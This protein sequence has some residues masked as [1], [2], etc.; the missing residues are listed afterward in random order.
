MNKR[1]VSTIAIGILVLPGLALAVIP[2][3]DQ[4]EHLGVQSCGASSCH[5]S[6]SVRNTY[7]VLQNEYIT[8]ARHDMHSK[9]YKVLKNEQSQRIAKNLGLDAAHTAKICL[10]CHS[11]NVPSERRGLQFK[12]SDGV[13]CEACHGGA[14][15]WLGIHI[16]GGGDK[17]AESLAAG[18]YPTEEPE[19]RAEL[20]L[21]CH[22]GTK[23]KFAT[24][25]IMGAGHPR[26]SFDLQKFTDIQ[27]RHY[28]VDDDY[29]ERKVHVEDTRA[30][31]M[32]QVKASREYMELLQ[33][34]RMTSNGVFPELGLFDCHACHHSIK[35][36]RWQASDRTGMPP[37]SVLLNDSS[38]AMSQIIASVVQ[39]GAARGLTSGIRQLHAASQ[40]DMAS[41]KS[42]AAQLESELAQLAETL[43]SREFG[44]QQ[45]N[46]LMKAMADA[47]G[48]GKFSDYSDAE[49]ATM[50]MDVFSG[51]TGSYK[52]ELDAMYE[53]V[54]DQEVQSAKRFDPQMF[55]AVFSGNAPIAQNRAPLRQASIPVSTKP[56]VMRRPA[57]V[58]QSAQ[59]D[60]RMQIAQS[61]PVSASAG[62]GSMGE[63][64]HRISSS[65]LRVRS[66]PR[67]NA[68][69]RT[70]LYRGQEVEVTGSN[71][72]WSRVNYSEGGSVRSGWVSSSYLA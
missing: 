36:M 72:D 43:R 33:G 7:S 55:A 37:G 14:E 65:A 23:D 62:S 56:A 40:K 29:R 60:N 27:P 15:Q 41:I 4:F 64:T 69:I 34:S 45:N 30:W 3:H 68:P 9:A 70:A 71:G 57:P 50:A 67:A 12:L 17:H 21:S 44:R 1:I 26:M 13:A 58:A 59:S 39:P 46:Q 52:N 49:Q 42:A 51:V 18:L 53:V 31:A 35:E 19:A 11:D 24:H 32:G 28:R 61:A 5:G 20:C 38:L 22:L 48:E 2:Q 63:P 10:D 16:S 25:E 47:I 6:A 54:A 8:W 66:E